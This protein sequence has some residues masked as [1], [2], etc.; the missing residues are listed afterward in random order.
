[1]SHT[2][3]YDAFDVATVPPAI[4]RYLRALDEDSLEWVEQT[5]ADEAHVTDEGIDYHG[6]DAIRGWLSK[7]GS[8][9]TY[10]RTLT[11]QRQDAAD[12][13]T[14]RA[15]LEGDFPGGVV[16]LLFRFTLEGDRISRLSIGL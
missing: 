12:R 4:T 14:V 15:H 13:W 10:T 9:Y 6:H 7:T 2:D 8:A 11:G 1:M 16:D 3:T 5:F